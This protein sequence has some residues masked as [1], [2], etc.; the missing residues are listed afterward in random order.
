MDE[1]QTLQEFRADA[2]AP[3]PAR[4]AAG[5]QR[6]LDEQVRTGRTRRFLANWKLAAVG[7]AAAVTAA[8][9]LTTQLG[10]GT[11]TQEPRP[12]SEHGS[13]AEPRDGQ[14]IY[15]KVVEKQA[16]LN[17]VND[18]NPTTEE[19]SR[20]ASWPTMETE[21]W[22]Q[23]GSGKLFRTLLNPQQIDRTGHWNWGS[24]KRMRAKVAKL[25]DD[26]QK[27]FLALRDVI[28]VAGTPQGS[29]DSA[30]YW[31]IMV[32]LSEVDLI[33]PKVRASLYRAL[34]EIP[35]VKIDRTFVK[36]AIGRPALAVYEPDF[37]FTGD[38]NL[39]EELL[40]DP[41]TFEYRGKR[42]LY[43]AGG[44]LDSK[45]TTKDTVVRFSALVKT[46]VVDNHSLRP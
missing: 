17:F 22:T 26:P 1:M 2:P 15:R 19:T 23:Y 28:P 25:P 42:T 4:L 36:D 5:R 44:K 38:L 24:P 21:S 9:V 20:G 12:Q 33:P 41:A 8:A 13:V 10:A 46:A 34:G 16:P 29:D 39:R 18:L 32:L 7:A 11:V 27:L 40:L 30:N 35:G 3:D 43:L 37:T 31:R 6:L 14:W 45:I